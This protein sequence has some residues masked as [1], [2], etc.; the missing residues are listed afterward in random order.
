MAALDIHKGKITQRDRMYLVDFQK[1]SGD[2]R[3][4]EV[5]CTA[6]P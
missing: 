5:A 4:Y 1:F 6:G 3:L 2:E